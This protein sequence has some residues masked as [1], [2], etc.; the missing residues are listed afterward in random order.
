[1]F[2]KL[3]NTS[4]I[5]IDG[6]GYVLRYFEQETMR[7]MRRYSCEVVLSPSDWIILDDDSLS[8]LEMKVARLAPAMVYSRL[9]AS[10]TSVAA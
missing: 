2:P 7:G 3:M 6:R 8:S 4:Q 10:R 5:E 9:L 1:M